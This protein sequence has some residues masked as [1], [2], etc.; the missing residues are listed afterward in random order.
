MVKKRDL[1]QQG[2][3]SM[4]DLIA[5]KRDGH[6]LSTPQIDFIIDGYT[7]G[8]IPDYQMSALSMAIVLRGMSDA[9]TAAL[10][11]AMRDSGKVIDLSSVSAPCI[12]KHST[13][14]VGDKVSICLAPMV[15][16][17]GVAV[18]MISGRGLGHTGGTL[19][20][21]QSIPGFRVD[22]SPRQ[23]IRQL[24]KLGCA[25]IGQ[26]NDIAPADK[27]LY[28][29]RD[30]TATV[31]SVPLITASIL[32]KKLAAGIDGLVLD[33]KTGSGAFMKTRKD[34]LMLA[35]SLVRV[36]RMA[37]KR[38][39]AFLT[40]MDVPLGK[41]IGNAL[42]TREAFEILQGEGPDDV[43][44]CTLVLGAEMLRIAGVTTGQAKGHQLLQQTLRD[45]SAIRLMQRVI[46]AQHGDARVVEEPDRLPQARFRID[47]LAPR[48][49]VLTAID[50]LELGRCAVAMGAGRQRVEDNIDPA[51]GMVLR[52]KPGDRVLAAQPMITVHLNQRALSPALQSR[53]SQALRLG[54]QAVER[55]PM[56]LES[57][58]G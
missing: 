37:N 4:P 26:T 8:S 35:K 48:A 33:V 45:G 6:E 53:L 28:A 2:P 14:G 58:P 29:L 42:E 32:S 5:I 49:G 19:D 40:N 3:W 54:R 20:K 23:F 34:A 10:T 46:K 39:S 31:E 44:E 41:A 16:A 43:L 22:L 18:P 25:L 15:A 30:V 13:G 57:L 55:Q 50:T 51:V 12:D 21:L 9:E 24:Q 27:R 11:L 36:G 47:V 56:V 52:V 1:A 7:K 38:V 17:C